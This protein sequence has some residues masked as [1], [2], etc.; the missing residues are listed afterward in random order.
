MALSLDI[1]RHF[2]P[3][4]IAK[5]R[6]I[7]E[8]LTLHAE[9]IVNDWVD[10][11]MRFEVNS[12]ISREKLLSIF[13][14][15]FYG[16]LDALRTGN[17]KQ[18]LSVQLPLIGKSL[19]EIGFPY[20]HLVITVHFL[21]ESYLPYLA[22]IKEGFAPGMPA[23]DIYIVIDEFWHFWIAELSYAYFREFHRSLLEE[24]EMGRSIQESM[25]PVIPPQIGCLE[26][27]AF[28]ASATSGAKIG[29]DTYDV[30]SHDEIAQDILVSDFSGKGLRAAVKA[31]NIRALFRGFAIEGD[32]LELIA[33]RLNQILFNELAEDEFNTAFLAHFDQKN[34]LLRYV[35]AG[36]P[37]PVLLEDGNSSVLSENENPALGMFKDAIFSER[38]LTLKPT[39][40]L[41]IYT[42]GVIEARNNGK[43]FGI[44]G[45]VKS[46]KRNQ[47]KFPADAAELL[48]LDCLEFA[49]GK[50]DD[51]VAIL[52]LRCE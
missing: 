14:T 3:G 20:E 51:D 30:V 8:H 13:T 33:N 29:G 39:S 44:E 23:I 42:D 34:R 15:L 22:E 25:R 52:V 7:A 10:R 18:Y 43:F 4:D 5:L 49:N 28:Y 38:S 48:W 16:T 9:E 12:K 37:G 46:I 6:E 41:V 36:H 45:V 1:N 24:V 26:I 21:E 31:A 19:V 32:S 40:L 11:Q 35:N 17:I 47:E 27:G 2:S 50:V